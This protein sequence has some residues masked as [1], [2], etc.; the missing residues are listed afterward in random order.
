MAVSKKTA[1]V[2]A[3]GVLALGAG[4]GVANMA[5]ADTTPTP[6]ANHRYPVT[7]G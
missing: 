1:I 5:S 4:F 3:S 6:S 2:I 7:G